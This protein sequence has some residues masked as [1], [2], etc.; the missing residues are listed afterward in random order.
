MTKV[1]KILCFLAAVTVMAVS[2]SGC[3]SKNWFKASAQESETSKGPLPTAP[4]ATFKDLDGKDV[5]LASLK[6]KV[7]VLNFWATWSPARW[8]SLG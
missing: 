5:T 6:G 2:F 7:V 1:F 8:K 4:D 3:N